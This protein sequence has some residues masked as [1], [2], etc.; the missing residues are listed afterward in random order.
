M[1][2]SIL[3]EDKKSV[4]LINNGNIIIDLNLPKYKIMEDLKGED[5]ISENSLKLSTPFEKDNVT[6]LDYE[7]LKKYFIENNQ[8][9]ITDF[10]LKISSKM[11]DI[12][13]KTNMESARFVIRDN[14]IF[15]NNLSSRDDKKE[16][17]NKGNKTSLTSFIKNYFK[18]KST[19]V[20]DNS[21]EEDEEEKF[22]VIRFFADV[23]ITD[24]EAQESYR[25]RITEFINCIGYTE[26]TGQIALKEKLFERLVINKYE[27]ILYSNG[28]YKVLPEKRLVELT[29]KAP[30]A[31]RL[32]YIQNYTRSIPLD[33]IKAKIEMDKLE[34]FDNYVILHYDP[35]N[36]STA[37]TNEE[38]EKEVKKAKDPILFGVIAGSTN[39]YYIADWIDEFCDLQFDTIVEILGK[40][41]VEKEFLTDKIK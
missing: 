8:D 32:D 1:T 13:K 23:K 14:S 41:I 33:V 36:I 40:E 17:E 7:T 20:K 4:A 24:K 22:D 19:N 35:E 39:L 27:S 21:N 9:N 12:I 30:K 25:N 31:L 2:N 15:L 3:T 11:R 6:S 29:Q 5:K 10:N 16:N 37:K 18:G 34:V 38:K 28:I 26:Q